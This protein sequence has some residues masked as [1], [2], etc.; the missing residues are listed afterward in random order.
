M[1]TAQAKIDENPIQPAEGRNLHVKFQSHLHLDKIRKQT[2]GRGMKRLHVISQFAKL[3]LRPYDCFVDV[4]HPAS[5]GIDA[6]LKIG[7]R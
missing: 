1:Y 2:F 3:D 6:K 5:I 7:I 4:S